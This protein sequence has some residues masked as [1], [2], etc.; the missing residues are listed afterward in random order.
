[1]LT[2]ADASQAKGVSE[3]GIRIAIRDG[4]LKAEQRGRIYLIR[5]SDLDAWQPIGH[6]PPRVPRQQ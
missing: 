3:N 2:V 4:R 1:V 5:R 6:R